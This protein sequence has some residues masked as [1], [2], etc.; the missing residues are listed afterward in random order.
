MAYEALAR[1]YRPRTFDDFVGQEAIARTLRNAIASDKVSHAYLFCG[2]RGTGKTSM[3]RVFAM[4]LNCR[5]SPKPTT[6]PC[7]KCDACLAIQRGDDLDVQEMDGASNRGID[8]VRTL[9]ENT[10]FAPN[11]TRFKIYYIDEAHM[12]TME[13]FNALLKTLEEP[14]GHVKFILATTAPSKIPETIHSRCQ[15]FD[16]RRISAL[17]ITKRLE[18]VCGN[19]GLKI[20]E[21]VLAIIARRARGSMRDGLSLLDQVIAFAGEDATAAKV[22]TMLGGVAQERMDELLGTVVQGDIAGALR[23][24]TEILDFGCDVPDLLEQLAQYARSLLIAAECGPASDLLERAKSEAEKLVERSKAFS[25]DL[26]MYIIQALYDAR[27]KAR[28]DL[29][30]RIVMELALVK[31]ARARAM[32]NIDDML[33]R[34]ESLEGRPGGANAPA[35]HYARGPAPS[36]ELRPAAAESDLIDD[37]GQIGEP[38]AA[39]PA[40]TPLWQRLMNAV[41]ANGN[42]WV[43]AQILQGRLKQVADDRLVIALPNKTAL[44]EL[45]SAKT[46]A[47]LEST[48]SRVIGKEISLSF[49]LENGMTQAPD[50]SAAAVNEE[51]KGV[52]DMFGGQVIKRRKPRDG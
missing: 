1:K 11:R 51:L 49:V 33:A 18:Y 47:E 28:L 46:R 37:S 36:R 21:E 15:R 17:D 41:Q 23:L 5:N 2:S 38:V 31:I 34:L 4:A 12:L 42:S 40:D 9:R 24:S 39:Y 19:E 26:L 16:F 30:S 25:P 52:A 10:R 32:G 50:A 6:E 22:E 13:A 29:D 14:P 7:G 48:F 27:Q 8:Q 3:A 43:R 44:N 45:D 20:P 35:A